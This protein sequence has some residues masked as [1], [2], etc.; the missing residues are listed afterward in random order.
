VDVLKAGNAPSATQSERI[1]DQ[2]LTVRAV[3]LDVR[4]EATPEELA[5]LQVA[6]QKLAG[7]GGGGGEAYLSGWRF[8]GLL[9]NVEPELTA[10]RAASVPVRP[11]ISRGATRA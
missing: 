5:A 8:A 4:P 3:D 1:P 2:S 11:R 7:G 10:P 9:E 6:F